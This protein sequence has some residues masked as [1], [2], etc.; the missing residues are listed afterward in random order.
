MTIEV[1]QAEFRSLGEQYEIDVPT[2]IH[3]F[4]EGQS[5]GYENTEEHRVNAYV[6]G[7]LID[8]DE[9]RSTFITPD[10]YVEMVLEPKDGG[11]IIGAIVAAVVATA[12]AVLLRPS[13]PSIG[14]RN[15]QQGSSIYEVNAQG[16][17]PKLGDV[18]PEQAGRHKKYPDVLTAPVRRFVNQR[19]QE[20]QLFLSLGI[21][22]FERD[23]EELKIG[24]TPLNA[25]GGAS[26]QFFEPGENVTGH[27]AHENWYNAPEVGSA[28]GNA[29]LRMRAANEGDADFTGLA[30]S[31]SNILTIGGGY[32]PQAW[33][34]SIDL[35]VRLYQPVLIDNNGFTIYGDFRHLRLGMP[36]SMFGDYEGDFTVR[37]ITNDFIELDDLNG[38]PVN[39]LPPGNYNL[40][41][42]LT[43][44]FY[45]ILVRDE[46]NTQIRV[47]RYHSDETVDLDWNTFPSLSN[48][49]ANI[50]PAG[51]LDALWTG[52]FLACPQ[53]ETTAIIEVDIFCPRGI[54]IIEDDGSIVYRERT[55]EIQ[56]RDYGDANWISIFRTVG[57]ASRDQLGWTFFESLPS[58]ITPEVR[59]RRLEE[60]DTGTQSIDELQWYGL[61]SRLVA[62]TS[63]ENISTLAI[64]IRG[65]D[66][67]ASQTENQINIVET[68]KI[69]R[70]N[71]SAWTAPE[72]TRDIS[73][74]VRYIAHSVGYTD[75]DIDMD[76]LIRLHGI[77]TARGET[78]NIYQDE[79]TTVK[80]ALNTV[81]RAGMSELTTDGGR[82]T[83]VRDGPRST[84]EH[85]YSPQN[86]IEGGDLSVSVTTPR[87]DDPDG[88]DVEYFDQNSW[89]SEIV[90]CRLPG[91]NGFR[92]EKVRLD[93]VTDRQ[94]AFRIGMRERSRQ[95]YTRWQYRFATPT[96]ALNSKYLSYCVV[97]G[98]VPGFAQSAIIEAVSQELDG[99]HIESSE[100]LDW[101][102]GVEH[103]ISWR[104]DD[105]T[106][107]GAWPAER[108][109]DN[110]HVI[111]QIPAG[112]VPVIQRNM[113]PPHLL[114]GEGFHALVRNIEPDDESVDVTAENYDERVY[115]YDDATL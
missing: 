33:Q 105:G 27:P 34:E 38:D 97:A 57:G 31:G 39:N 54:G 95:K 43:G 60:E 53:S 93:G 106:Y 76:E 20:M 42:D 4:V 51:P 74:W 88:I 111:A 83:P 71:G 68:R 49:T 1:Y 63:Y 14:G 28:T 17:Q 112:E 47:Q 85:M 2:T 72:P 24:S 13:I 100:P 103:V 79:P 12:A 86:Y 104:R 36:V 23:I 11:V 45:R 64:T 108:G 89:T 110:Y 66:L 90:K 98:E 21:G 52:P 22:S 96:D 55:V 25:L 8:Q 99:V 77:W 115:A 94:Q 37:S 87:H 3:D 6:N 56:Y 75:A 59:V 67:I 19:S 35:I 65:S 26:F 18:I 70:W 82:I 113:E 44:A 78:F 32:L 73:A 10:D 84:P 15:S 92:A 69:P 40:A 50:Y 46:E 30:F 109:D 91:D 61:R 80:E 5:P 114:F 101:N 29:G 9:W 107:S 16:N 41:I 102:S 48:V 7:S 58:A 62:N 81:L